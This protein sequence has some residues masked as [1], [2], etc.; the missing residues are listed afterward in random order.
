MSI[1]A[2]HQNPEISKW[3]NVDSSFVRKVRRELVASNYDYEA[4]AVRDEHS[5]RS[6]CM[7]DA[8][9]IARVQDMVNNDPGRSMRAMARELHVSEKLIR[10]C[11]KEDIR[12]KSYKMRRGQLLTVKMRENRLKKSQKLLNKLKHPMEN[13][14]ICFFQMRKTSVR[15]KPTTLRTI[16]GWPTALRMCLG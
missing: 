5:R 13:N 3:L 1:H 12:Y 7:R 14:M 15:T 10:Q 16:G 2:G 4:T 6:D 8:E 11:V 9:F